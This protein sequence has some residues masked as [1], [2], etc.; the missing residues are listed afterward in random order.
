M[1]K[2]ETI[3]KYRREWKRLDFKRLDTVC[4]LPPSREHEFT[5]PAFMLC[6][7]EARPEGVEEEELS[8]LIDYAHDCCVGFRMMKM[9]VSGHI[10]W[11]WNKEEDDIAFKALDPKKTTNGAH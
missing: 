9:L 7:L 4:N 5:Y 8:K 1:N 3:E 10:A 2:Q 11:A 6:L